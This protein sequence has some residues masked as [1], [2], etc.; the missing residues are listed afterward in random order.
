[1]ALV[2]ERIHVTWHKV[3]AVLVGTFVGP[4]HCHVPRRGH[5]HPNN[6]KVGEDH[7]SRAP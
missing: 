2:L 5:K 1:M 6:L 7:V 4:L 3:D